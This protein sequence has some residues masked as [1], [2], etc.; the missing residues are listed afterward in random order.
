MLTGDIHSSWAMDL[1]YDPFDAAYD[2]DTGAGSL[3]VELVAPGISS[4]GFPEQLA[5]LADGLVQDNPHLKWAELVS[6]GYV[7]LDIDHDRV[8]AAWHLVDTV[9]VPSDTEALAGVLAVY[10]GAPH[11][12]IE[13]S[14]AEPPSGVDPPAPAG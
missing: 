13:E 6:R 2:P 4:P 10:A 11:L 12:V 9:D 3:A 8:Q 7:V 1:P 5:G 14:A